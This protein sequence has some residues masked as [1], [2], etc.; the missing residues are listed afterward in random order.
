[1]PNRPTSIKPAQ[2][3][4]LPFALRGTIF[5]L[6]GKFPGNDRAYPNG[7]LC[8]VVATRIVLRLREAGHG[9]EHK[10]GQNFFPL[11]KLQQPW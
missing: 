8:R 5:I 1:M 2:R 9:T 7:N 10:R 4:I 11:V 6:G 3:S